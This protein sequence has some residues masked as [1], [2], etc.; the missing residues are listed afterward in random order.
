M[1]TLTAPAPRRARRGRTT[2]APPPQ[3]GQPIRFGGLIGIAV[4]LAAWVVGSATG[5][6]DPR[7]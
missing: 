6:L 3:P 7:T 5:L 1:T 4:L 2:R